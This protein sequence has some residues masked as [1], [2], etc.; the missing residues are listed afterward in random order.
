MDKGV[1]GGTSFDFP[2]TDQIS[3]LEISIA[4]FEL[5]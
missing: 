4:V 5:P 3:T 1:S 2:K